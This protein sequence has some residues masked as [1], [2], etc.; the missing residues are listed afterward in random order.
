MDRTSDSQERVARREAVLFDLDG[1]LID[2]R[3]VYLACHRLAA[4]EV[5]GIE[6][7]EERV[8]E[9]MA[10]G[11]PIRTH[12]AVLSEQ[13]ADRLVDRFVHHY[14]LQRA[15]LARPFPGI[16]EL[17]RALKDSGTAI[18]VVTS[19]LRA[20]AVAELASTGLAEYVDTLVAFEDVAEHKPSPQPQLEALHRLAC[21]IGVGIGDLPTDIAS[22]RAAGLPALGVTWGYADRRTL[23][24]AGAH[25]VCETPTELHKALT[26][27]LDTE[28]FVRDRPKR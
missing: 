3:E 5:L 20:D 12:M 7:S 25:R 19:K 13:N 9:L 22:A 14:R 10:T 18:A 16:V 2:L 15:S 11:V 26:A 21:R 1:T 28:L 27:C 23:A 6:L 4:G 24:E 17:L 8:L